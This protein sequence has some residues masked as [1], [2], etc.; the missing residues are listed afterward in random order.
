M[1]VVHH[2]SR[3]CPRAR[4]IAHLN[5]RKTPSLASAFRHHA[6]L[7]GTQCPTTMW[8]AGGARSS[9][10]DV[11][12]SNGDTETRWGKATTK[13]T[14]I[15]NKHAKYTCI[16]QTTQQESRGKK[17]RNAMLLVHSPHKFHT[18]KENAPWQCLAERYRLLKTLGH[19]K[20]RCHRECAITSTKKASAKKYENVEAYIGEATSIELFEPLA[21]EATQAQQVSLQTTHRSDWNT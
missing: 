5:K 10:C 21:C 9:V 16:E 1:G 18:K 4:F 8:T 3:M 2:A 12:V 19:L 7:N 20:R 13:K 11:D 15:D 14:T 6:G 17:R